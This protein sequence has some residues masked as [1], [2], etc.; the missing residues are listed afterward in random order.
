MIASISGSSPLSRPIVLTADAGASVNFFP[1]VL[2][3]ALFAI[4]YFLVIRPQQSQRRKTQDML[5]NLKTGDRVVTT[6]GLYGTV[7]GFQEGVVQLQVAPQVRV[8]V[9]RVAI[10]SLAAVGGEAKG[11]TRE[12]A[13]REA[14]AKGR[15]S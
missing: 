7:V 5:A 13:R 9:A 2:F 14:A 15:R 1:L 11:E 3:A 6:G 4:W 10:S 12:P 8:D